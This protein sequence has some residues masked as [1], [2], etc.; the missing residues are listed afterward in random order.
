MAAPR[1]PSRTPFKRRSMLALGATLPVAAAAAVATRTSFAQT[2][3]PMQAGVVVDPS[4]VRQTI[5]GFGG[6][7]HTVWI[8]D[9]TAAQRETAFG[10]GQGQLGFTIL[11]IPVHEDRANWSREV[12]T[13]QRASELGAKVIASPWNPPAAMIENFSGGRRLR[14]DQYAAYAQHLNDFT[15]FMSDNGVNLYAISVQN[16]P[17]YAEE[18]TAWTATE[19]TRFLRE[20]AGSLT[21]RVIAPESFQYRKNLSDPILNDPQALANM[22]ILGAHLYGTQVADFPYPL[23]QQNGT[24]KELWMTEVY[25]PNSSDSADL[26]PQ[27]L[28]VG[29]HVHRALVDGQFQAYIWWYIRRYYGPMLDSGQIS[30]RGANLAHFSKFVRPGYTRVQA[31]ANPQSN[32]YVSAYKGGD[33]EIVIVAVNKNASAVTLP[34]SLGAGGIGSVASWVTDAGRTLSSQ[35]PLAVSNGS[36]TATLAAQSITTFVTGEGDGGGGDDDDDDDNGG[37]SGGCRGRI[38]IVGD[39]GGSWQ[40]RV[41]LSA[42]EQAVNGWNVNWTWP[43]GQQISSVWNAGWSQSGATVTASDVGWNGQIAAGQEREVFGF[44][45]SGPAATLEFDC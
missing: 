34:F 23:F 45:A 5:Q 42:G 37:G 30:K 25:H 9:L 43:G 31:T 27:A 8:D 33:G 38:E 36:F 13:A 6:M 39:W 24:G 2:T 26:W 22:D 28:N 3:A 44:I 1:E 7:N 21:T 18:W 41:V 14:Y 29:E 19:I 4:A 40:G 15:A 10:N 16:E 32:V 35:S 12:A 17:D 11:R 20:N